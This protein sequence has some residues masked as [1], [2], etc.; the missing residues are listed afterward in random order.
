MKERLGL[1]P[2]LLPCTVVLKVAGE[3]RCRQ[4]PPPA[5]TGRVGPDSGGG[6]GLG[7]APSGPH[8]PAS[9]QQGTERALSLGFPIRE[10]EEQPSAG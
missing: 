2:A 5:P 10:T 1:R 9:H 3:T 7:A 8:Q 4:H 6:G